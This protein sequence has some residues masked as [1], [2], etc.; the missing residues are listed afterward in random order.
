MTRAARGRRACWSCPACTNSPSTRSVCLCRQHVP[1]LRI[2]VISVDAGLRALCVLQVR[3]RPHAPYQLLS[4]GFDKS[5]VMTDIRQP[6]V[7]ALVVSALSLMLRRSASLR[8]LFFF[9][10]VMC[11]RAPSC[12]RRC[13][14][15]TAT[16]QRISLGCVC[17]SSITSIAPLSSWCVAIDRLAPFTTRSLRTTASLCWCAI[18]GWTSWPLRDSSNAWLL[19][20]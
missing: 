18:V 1:F 4:S 19:P 12:R 15:P 14:A 10:S 3:W 6:Q 7:Q 17:Q 2:D 9:D 5:L 20:S 8:Y 16:G 11:V 13:S